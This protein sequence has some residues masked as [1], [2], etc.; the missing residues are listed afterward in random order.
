VLG[1]GFDVRTL[2]AKEQGELNFWI[3]H[4]HGGCERELGRAFHEQWSEGARG[5]LARF[6]RHIPDLPAGAGAVWVDVG[7]GPYSVLMQAPAAVTK[8]MIDPLIEHY[9]RCGLIDRRTVPPASVFLDAAA[10]DLPLVDG[11]ADFVVCTN[12]LDH[13]DDP[14][15]TTTELARVLKPGGAL[16]LEVDTG[17]TTDY[18][19][20][21]AIGAAAI[22][23]HF[24]A[25]GLEK[26]AGHI[27]ADQGRRRPG[28]QL[29]RA[30]Y[31]RIAPLS[32]ALPMRAIRDAIH[33]VLVHEGLHGFN[34]VRLRDPEEG[35]WFYALLQS[36]GAFTRDKVD[37]GAY[38]VLFRGRTLELVQQ[39]VEAYQATRRAV[40]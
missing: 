10:E 19:H 6:A 40:R 36:D 1:G 17:G 20:P 32:T 3:D 13:V 21:H 34:I 38:R 5:R 18:M 8:V 7:T 2:S 28:A 33:P 30:Y 4:L 35:D 23:D 26:I 24:A 25:A 27:P 11:S 22:D 29:Y 14:W 12:T 31:R 16:A 39:Q 9:F 15:A 37:N